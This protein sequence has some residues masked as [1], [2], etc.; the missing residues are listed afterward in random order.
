MAGSDVPYASA[1][2]GPSV[3]THRA[4]ALEFM[5]R[6]H[7]VR[8]AEVLP[9]LLIVAVYFVLPDRITFGTQVMIVIMFTLS[10]DLILGY[11]GIVTLGHA[12]FFG[13]GAYTVAL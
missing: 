7:R 8:L 13:I 10:L 3:P 2:V 5:T 12:A 1:V 4:N 6:R 11:A 9:W